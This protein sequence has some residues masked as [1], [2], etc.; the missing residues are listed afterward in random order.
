[1]NS[2]T[3]TALDSLS[4]SILHLLTYF[5][6]LFLSPFNMSWPVEFEDE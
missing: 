2:M 5:T 6:F 1:M 3:N 4:F